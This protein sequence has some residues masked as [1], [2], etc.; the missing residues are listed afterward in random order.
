MSIKPFS[1]ADLKVTWKK[2]TNIIQNILTENDKHLLISFKKGNPDWSL[3]GIE[4]LNT[5]PAV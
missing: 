5:L 3:C 1:Y 4:K 2:V